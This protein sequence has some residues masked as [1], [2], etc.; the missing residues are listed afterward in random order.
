[1]KHIMFVC[2]GNICRSPAAEAVFRHITTI[3]NAEDRYRADSAGTAAY[4]IGSPADSRMRQASSA[5]GIRITHRGQQLKRVHLRQFDLILCMDKENLADACS[6]TD[7]PEELAKIKLFRDFDPEGSGDVPD[8]Y[9]GGPAG[10]ETVLDIAER[11]A[12][13]LFEHLERDR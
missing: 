8:P 5:R 4:H 1:M 9:Y 7:A 2:L 3:N 10:F 13:S 6:L 11:S 12:A